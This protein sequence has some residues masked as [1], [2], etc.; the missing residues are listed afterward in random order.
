MAFPPVAVF[1]DG[2]ELLGYT[3]M[4]L[5]RSKESLTGNL[6]VDMF[7]GYVPTSPVVVDAA[8]SKQV[9]VYIGGQLAFT[10]TLDKR[11][12]SGIKHG[13]PGSTISD[14]STGDT[15]RAAS[16]GPNEYTVKLTARGKTKRLVDSSHQHRTTNY[17]QPT[18][19]DVI[20]DLV[21]PFDVAVEFIGTEIEVDKIR[22]R[23]GAK[24]IEELR[25]LSIENGYYIY[26][27]RDGK[28]RVTDDVG[29]GV[30]DNLILGQNILSFSAE[31]SEDQAQSEITVKGQR[32]PKNMWGEDAVL[33]QTV[34]I[35]Q[36]DW[37]PSFAP[38]IVQ[39]YGDA[40]E[41]ALERR[42]RFEANKRS[43]RSKQVTIEVF[44]VQPQSGAPWDVGQMHY[45]EIPPEGIFDMFECT[46]VNYTVENDRTLKTT[47]TLSPPP[48]GQASVT[49]LAAFENMPDD[50][51]IGAA[52]RRA[53]LGVT[54][55]PGTYPS[56]WS[57]PSLVGR[58]V[59]AVADIIGAL[60]GSTG[61][62]RAARDDEPTTPP[63]H[64]PASFN[65]E[66]DN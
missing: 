4:T 35:V 24:V 11:Q 48:T 40:T 52:S 19:R 28:L 59:N 20:N 34:K 51:L 41:E 65:R 22:L 10:G 3:G 61:L 55:A 12:G 36:D 5:S 1:V 26:E 6:S 18:T 60:T 32:T 2:Q 33:N 30:G 38:V 54:F 46:A 45:V 14:G 21:A 63:L 47:L 66:A 17:M 50:L 8:I 39:H 49:G 44:H 58:L 53:A 62:E 64:L 29:I 16:I 31:Q 37:V 7:F 13:A 15:S 27:T 43:S 42:A 23:D 56:P 57:G 25:R 9:L